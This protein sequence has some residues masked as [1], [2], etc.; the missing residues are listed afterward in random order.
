MPRH[1]VASWMTDLRRM[2]NEWDFAGT[3][4]DDE[5]DCLVGPLLA[6]LAD[7]ADADDI[8]DFLAD[9]IEDHYG[10]DPDHVDVPAFAAR[11][12]GWWADRAPALDTGS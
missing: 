12:V 9:E 1:P 5:Y 6:E 8:A 3:G 11:A 7:G 2:L 4:A 10:L